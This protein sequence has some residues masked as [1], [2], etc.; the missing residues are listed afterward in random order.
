MRQPSGKII[1]GSQ[2]C[3]I[4]N[5]DSQGRMINDELYLIIRADVCSSKGGVYRVL[6]YRSKSSGRD[7]SSCNCK[8]FFFTEMCKHIYAVEDRAHNTK[9]I[10]Y[11]SL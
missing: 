7:W 4:I 2:D 8:G 3:K 1:K 6:I 9:S 11:D 10:D 5:L